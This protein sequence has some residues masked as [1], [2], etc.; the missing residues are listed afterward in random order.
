[1][2]CALA[3]G[4]SPYIWTASECG[5]YIVGIPQE[6]GKPPRVKPRPVTPLAERIPWHGGCDGVDRN[7]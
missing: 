5:K 7:G 4:S 1:M 2:S 3:K 6:P